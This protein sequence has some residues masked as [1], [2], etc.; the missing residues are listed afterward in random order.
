MERN[1]RKFESHTGQYKNE[2]GDQQ[3]RVIRCNRYGYIAEIE[4]ARYS[5]EE[6]KAQQE[7]SRREN[8]R[9]EVFGSR[10]IRFRIFLIDSYQSGHR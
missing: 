9:K 5:I 2:R 7:D 8:R 4:R 3:W 10:L 1:Q 6:R